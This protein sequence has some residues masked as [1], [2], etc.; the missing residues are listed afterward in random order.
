LQNVQALAYSSQSDW[1]LDWQAADVPDEQDSPVFLLGF[2]RS[3]TTL[4]EQILGAHSGLAAMEEESVIAQ[5][6]AQ[7]E[8]EEED[9]LAQLGQ[10]PEAQLEEL[11]EQYFRLAS[12]HTSLQAGQR[13]LDKFPLNTI[14]LPLIQRLF[15]RAKLVLALRHP[16]DVVLSCFMQEFEL[17]DAMVHFTSLSETTDLYHAVMSICENTR[18]RLDLQVQEVRYENLVEDLESTVRRLLDFLGLEWEP[19]V[20]DFVATA[21]EKPRIRTPSYDQVSQP[22]YR[23][24]SLRWLR[25]RDHLSGIVETLK[26]LCDRYAYSLELSAQDGAQADL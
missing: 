3:G 4:L 11:R 25:Y 17:N 10:L 24:A 5:L 21:A 12:Q 20:L 18:K 26:P 23:E 1:A 14:H 7:L 15:P 2:P 16:C 9:Y 22:I 6:G 13:L 19:R 8:L